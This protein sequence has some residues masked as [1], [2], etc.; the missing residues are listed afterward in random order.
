MLTSRIYNPGYCLIILLMLTDP[1]LVEKF[2]FFLVGLGLYFIVVR[3]WKTTASVLFRHRA[4][5]P[6]KKG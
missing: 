1:L 2:Y 4:G 5:S 6:M 3:A